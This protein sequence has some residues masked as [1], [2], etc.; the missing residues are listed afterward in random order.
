MKKMR[1]TYGVFFIKLVDSVWEPKIDTEK[2]YKLDRKHG[3]IGDYTNRLKIITSANK[4]DG[5]GRLDPVNVR[6]FKS[7]EEF[8]TCISSMLDKVWDEYEN[9]KEWIEVAKDIVEDIDEGKMN[10][11]DNTFFDDDEGWINDLYKHDPL[12]E[13]ATKEDIIARIKDIKSRNLESWEPYVMMR[14]IYGLD[15]IRPPDIATD[16]NIAEMKSKQEDGKEERSHEFWV[17]SRIGMTDFTILAR[18]FYQPSIDK[19]NIIEKLECLCEDIH[20]L[21]MQDT[22]VW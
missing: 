2:V 7:R 21:L 14:E 22:Y 19:K 16:E 9:E 4:K 13:N 12:D 5:G 20:Q 1:K 18:G 8:K 6:M 17:I 10:N 15:F 11:Q 3:T